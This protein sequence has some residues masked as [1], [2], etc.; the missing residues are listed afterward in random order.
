MYAL[1]LS[2]VRNVLPAFEAEFRTDVHF[3]HCPESSD[4]VPGPTAVE[5]EVYGRLVGTTG[6]PA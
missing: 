1:A 4:F 3:P 5:F 6:P 2:F